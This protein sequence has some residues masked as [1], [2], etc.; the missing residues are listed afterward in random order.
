[1]AEVEFTKEKSE[2]ETKL[3]GKWS[4]SEVEIND[5]CF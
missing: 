2:T 3:F 5:K 1:M 4:Y